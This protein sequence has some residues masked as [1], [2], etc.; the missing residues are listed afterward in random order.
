[1]TKNDAAFHDS[2]EEFAL[3]LPE[4]WYDTP[5]GDAV[6]KVRKKIFVFLG[7]EREGIS[8][9]LTDSLEH[10]RNLPDAAPVGYGLGKSGW[11]Y[12]P[13]VGL[14]DGASDELCQTHRVRRVALVLTR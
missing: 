7:G 2:L 8:V 5:W 1:M 13:L 9:K 14:D 10:G 6:V 3:S 11:T 4:A 12:I